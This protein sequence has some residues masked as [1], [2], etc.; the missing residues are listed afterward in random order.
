VLSSVQAFQVHVSSFATIV[1]GAANAEAE[2]DEGRS[3]VAAVVS[4]VETRRLSAGD[5]IGMISSSSPKIGVG[6]AGS[7]CA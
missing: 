2:L 1:I 4:E 5:G 3:L 6:V 7:G